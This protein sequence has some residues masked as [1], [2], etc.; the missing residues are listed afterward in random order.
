MGAL[1]TSLS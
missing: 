1:K